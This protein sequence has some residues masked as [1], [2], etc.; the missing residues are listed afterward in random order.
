MPNMKSIT[1]NVSS[2]MSCGLEKDQLPLLKNCDLSKIIHFDVEY[3][4]S[5]TYTNLY[6]EIY[7]ILKT[8]LIDK[9]KKE[10]LDSHFIFKKWP[11]NKYPILNV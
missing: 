8:K 5:L 1:M 4:V 7:E 3:F 6:E 9:Y 11:P 2:N 10:D